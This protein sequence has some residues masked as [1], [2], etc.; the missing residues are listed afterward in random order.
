MRADDWG[1]DGVDTDVPNAARM[2]D[3][4][5][6]GLHNF[7]ADREM[8]QRVVGAYPALP[9]VL[10]QNRAFLRR[11]VRYLVRQGIRQFLDLGSGLPTVGNVHEVAQAEAPD[12]RVVYV[13]VDPTAVLHS[14][15]MLVGNPGATVLQL[16][17]R[18]PDQVL[19]H[20]D[21]RWQLDLDKPVAVLCM[22][23]VHFIG[24]AEDP[25][26]I[27]KAYGDQLAS[28]S[29]IALSSASRDI[30]PEGAARVAALYART[31]NPMYFRTYAEIS[32]FFGDY[33][34]V[35]PG[36]VL[37][38]DWHPEL[39]DAPLSDIGNVSGYCGVARKP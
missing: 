34:L 29:Y 10:Q 35:E 32:T 28:G 11:A 6:G 1:Q 20:R 22:A 17:L 5:L 14:R 7:P 21:L 15:L 31:G 13:D 23:V 9:G 37:P 8:A 19:S 24:D 30:D 39:A 12:A 36:L 27:M 2:Y 4:Y 3:Y 25:A 18:N 16:D 33:E 26:G 38:N